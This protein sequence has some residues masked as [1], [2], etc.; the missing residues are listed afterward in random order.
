MDS[1]FSGVRKIDTQCIVT[2]SVR[3]EVLTRNKDDI[4]QHSFT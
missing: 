4:L 2:F 1:A 3:K